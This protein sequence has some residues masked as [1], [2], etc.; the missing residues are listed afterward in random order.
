MT[1]KEQRESNWFLRARAREVKEDS[2]DG[3]RVKSE[4]RVRA[5]G[6]SPDPRYID[7]SIPPD[8]SETERISQHAYT[9]CWSTGLGLDLD[10]VRFL[11]RGCLVGDASVHVDQEECTVLDRL[12]WK[13]VIELRIDQMRREERDQVRSVAPIATHQKVLFVRSH[14]TCGKAFYRRRAR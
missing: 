1:R 14:P 6:A 2:C 13:S 11:T 7:R 10:D 5:V 8:S 9:R 12:G 4:V 3:G